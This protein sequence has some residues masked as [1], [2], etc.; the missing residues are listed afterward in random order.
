MIYY[1]TIKR[2]WIYN[3]AIVVTQSRLFLC[4]VGFEGVRAA[5][6]IS[7]VKL[8]AHCPARLPTDPL[9]N[10]T[11]LSVLPG[12]SEHLLATSALCVPL[13]VRRL[14]W[15]I[16]CSDKLSR[17]KAAVVVSLLLLEHWI[18]LVHWLW[19]L[20]TGA[21]NSHCRCVG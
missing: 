18:S 16:V 19:D 15:T 7:C 10:P 5:F 21:K 3:D 20:A 8:V 6:C 13:D 1:T 14:E 4:S 11:R 9:G 12:V 2:M 17:R